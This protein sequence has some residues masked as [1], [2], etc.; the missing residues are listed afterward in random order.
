MPDGTY[1][2]GGQMIE[3]HGN[4][5][6]ILGEP[7]TLAGSV[8]DLMACMKRAVSFGVPLADAVTAAAV[9]PAQ[10]IG[11]YDRM[12]SLET[13]KLANAAVL[14]QNLELKAVL[15]HGEIVHGV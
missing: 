10:A 13:G 4:R 15:F 2:F 11:I 14:D 6:T 3:V 1:P 9:N 7:D 12:G 5:A 8:S